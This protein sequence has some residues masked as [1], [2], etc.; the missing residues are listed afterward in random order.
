[1]IE[2]NYFASAGTAILING[3][4]DRWYEGGG[5]EDVTIRGNIFDNCLTSGNRDGDRHQWGEAVITIMPSFNTV[6]RDDETYHR[7]I[8]I[9]GNTFR[10]FD[11]PIVLARSTR[12][13]QFIGNTIT[14]T[15]DFKPYTWQRSAFLLDGCRE[16]KITGNFWDN[17]FN[18]RSV[19]Y[20]NMTKS[21]MKVKDKGFVLEKLPDDFKTYLEW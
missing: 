15:H 11:A 13:L 18:D 21:D 8:H 16:V 10:T 7:H 2:N 1:L 6:G 14:K 3:D 20:K 19:Q 5:C 17:A 12:D 4:T 9:T